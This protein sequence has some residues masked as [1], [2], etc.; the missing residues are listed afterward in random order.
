MFDIF[1]FQIGIHKQLQKRTR[2]KI[3]KQSPSVT[4]KQEILTL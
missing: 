3:G 4:G 1:F 2:Q